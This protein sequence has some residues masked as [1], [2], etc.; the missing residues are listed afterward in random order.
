M[1][2]EWY[3]TALPSNLAIFVDSANKPILVEN[4]KEA[5]VIE[6]HNMALEKKNAIEEWKCKKVS[7]KEDPTKKKP[8]D[9]FNLEGLQNVLKTMSNEMVNIKKQVAETSKKPYR[10]FKKNPSIHSKPPT[11]FQM[12][13]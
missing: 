4:M 10:P 1:R 5:I 11:L 6:K 8:K 9:P 13:N 2:S 12:L 7:F 3:I